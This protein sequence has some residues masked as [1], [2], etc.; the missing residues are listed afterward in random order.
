MSWFGSIM[1]VGAAVGSLVSGVAAD[2]LGRKLTIL[3]ALLL[4]SI[5]WLTM[6][7]DSSSMVAAIIGRMITGLGV[8]FISTGVPTYIGEVATADVRG[9]LGASFQFCG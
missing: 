9:T 2:K 7:F 4:L 6:I 1:T 8:G 5:G 3:V